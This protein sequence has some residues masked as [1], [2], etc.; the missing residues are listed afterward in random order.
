MRHPSQLTIQ[1]V[2]PAVVGAHERRRV[3]HSARNRSAS[4]TAN[5]PEGAYGPVASTRATTMGT[6]DI[7]RARYEPGSATAPLGKNGTVTDRNRSFDLE[8][9]CAQVVGN[10]LSP[11]TPI[12]IGCS[13]IGGAVGDVSSDLFHDRP[14]CRQ[15]AAPRV[16]GSGSSCRCSWA[17]LSST[18]RVLI[19]SIA[20]RPFDTEPQ[21]APH[22]LAQR[23]APTVTAPP[24]KPTH[25]S[26]VGIDLIQRHRRIT[27][28]LA[29]EPDVL[30]HAWSM[31]R[32]GSN[33][34]VDR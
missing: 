20:R 17:S 29:N 4:M 21:A 8:L 3:P 30:D 31:D 12:N 23:S 2:H 1:L 22:R 28:Q 18:I 9:R 13:K 14:T 7:V 33:V 24:R 6:P 16:F 34:T 26:V 5:V 19:F 32:P 25:R 15:P 11:H 10:E 27:E